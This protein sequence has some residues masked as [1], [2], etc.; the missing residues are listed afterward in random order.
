MIS[1]MNSMNGNGRISNDK[2]Y[3]DHPVNNGTYGNLYCNQ[4]ILKNIYE[5]MVVMS[6]KHNKVYFVR[7]DLRYPIGYERS[8]GS[9]HIS[10]LFKRLVE[11]YQRQGTD[12]RYIW[13]REQKTDQDVQHYHC[14]LLMDGNRVQSYFPILKVV[15]EIWGRILGRDGRGLV[16]Y[17]NRQG[18]GIMI[19]RP[20][21]KAVG[22][23]L[24]RQQNDYKEQFD[25]CFKWASYLAK[26][27]QKA[28]TPYSM[29]SYGAS[30]ISQEDRERVYASAVVWQT[31]I[32]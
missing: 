14:V 1:N 11:R 17:C 10:E 13:A 29:R 7:F 32:G 21:S 5:Q 20:S 22:H 30:R 25:Q 23:E 31:S 12:T 8:D 27:N 26:V 28:Y 3:Y 24:M 6:N 19:E 15:T 9:E 18:N 2:M 16:D 4:D